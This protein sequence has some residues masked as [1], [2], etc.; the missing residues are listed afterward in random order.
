MRC[1]AFGQFGADAVG[2]QPVPVCL[3]VVAAIT[4]NAFG[5]VF[6]SASLSGNRWNCFHQSLQ[7]G[8]IVAIGFG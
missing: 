3:R 5:L 8:D 7:L 4:L 6:W 1:T 2:M